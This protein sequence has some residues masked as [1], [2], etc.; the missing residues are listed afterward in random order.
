MVT[1]DN[2]VTAK[3]IAKECKILEDAGETNEDCVLE[4]PDFYRRMGGLI[5]K[6]CK[7]DAPCNCAPKDVV[8]GVK[9]I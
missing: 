8:E 5:C 7:K 2:L 4:G 9:N 1:G 6:T 3:A